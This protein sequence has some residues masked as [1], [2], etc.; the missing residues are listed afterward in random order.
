MNPLK[1]LWSDF[2]LALKIAVKKL[3]KQIQF[4]RFN[5]RNVSLL[6]LILLDAVEQYM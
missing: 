1:K 6:S 3:L 4:Q 5:F 2:E